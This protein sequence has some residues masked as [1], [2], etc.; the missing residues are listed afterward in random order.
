MKAAGRQSVTDIAIQETGSVETALDIAQRNNISITHDLTPGQDLSVP[1][2]S[3]KAVVNYLS[4]RS[5]RPA[6]QAVP[7]DDETLLFDN[8]FDETFE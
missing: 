3:N 7:V 2:P 6:T 4:S 5:A 8:V 1:G